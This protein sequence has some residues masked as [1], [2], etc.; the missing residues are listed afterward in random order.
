MEC[1]VDVCNDLILS[2]L[3]KFNANHSSDDNIEQFDAIQGFRLN[4]A[5]A[6]TFTLIEDSIYG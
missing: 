1:N 5:L 4:F 2:H 6:Q 3:A